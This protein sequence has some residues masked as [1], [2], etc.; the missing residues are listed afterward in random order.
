MG[1]KSCADLARA[2]DGSKAVV[3]GIVLIRQRPG[4]G[5][6]TFMTIEDETGI[7]NLIVWQRRFEEQRRVVMSA[8]MIAVRGTVQR[9][10][11]VIHVVTDRL[12]DHTPL[13]DTVGRMQFPHRRGRADAATGGGRDPREKGRGQSHAPSRTDIAETIRVKSRNFH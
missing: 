13:L 4:K 9:E 2:K 12:E 1:V 7:A 5:N 6:V 10:G 11:D 3:A 8:A